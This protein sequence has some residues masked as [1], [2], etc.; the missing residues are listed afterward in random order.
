M[1]IYNPN[2]YR[3]CQYIIQQRKFD[4]TVIFWASSIEPGSYTINESDI[5]CV[6]KNFK[7][8]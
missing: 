7:L 4:H 5:V 6:W 1:I 3:G 8:K 2:I